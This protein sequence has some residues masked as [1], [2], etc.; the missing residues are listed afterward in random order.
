VRLHLESES[1]A[2]DMH[3]DPDT[4][5]SLRPTIANVNPSNNGE[6]SRASSYGEKAHERS[7]PFSCS[8]L[9]IQFSESRRSSRDFRELS[10]ADTSAASGI[11]LKAAASP[12]HL[13]KLV[14]SARTYVLLHS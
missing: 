2:E 11:E 1:V 12:P 8:K 9:V 3:R 13:D 4:D 7:A 6:H 10:L 5:S 14:I